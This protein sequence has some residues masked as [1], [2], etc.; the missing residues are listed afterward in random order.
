[1]KLTFEEIPDK[2]AEVIENQNKIISLLTESPAN[3]KAQYITRKELKRMLSVSSDVTIIE[4][5]RKGQL[6]PYRMGK[7]VLYKVGEV[8]EALKSFNRK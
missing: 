6:T 5:E 1:M 4:M 8:E 2:M 7:R 3:Q